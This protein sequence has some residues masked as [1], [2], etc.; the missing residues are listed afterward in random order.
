MEFKDLVV[1][2]GHGVFSVDT[3][4]GRSSKPLLAEDIVKT[5]LTYN[6][7][8]V[9]PWIA[10]GMGR[11]LVIG[12]SNF[13]DIDVWF[14]NHRQLELTR[15]RLLTTYKGQIWQEY[16]SVNAETWTVGDYKIQLIKKKF[17]NSVEEVFDGFDFTC[18]QVA[19]DRN[20]RPY[21][22]GLEDAESG[23]LR[24]HCLNKDSFLARY[25]KYVG[26]GYAMPKEEFLNWIEKTQDI[27][28][29]FDGTAFGY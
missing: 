20:C 26:Y 28:Y 12:E 4:L 6:D 5:I 29:K 22:P 18:C 3:L 9:G 19:V 13:N 11:Q 23:R 7:N 17:F 25:A 27:N 1:K 24:V 16:N 14:N 10:G 21:G 8:T 2:L 15:N